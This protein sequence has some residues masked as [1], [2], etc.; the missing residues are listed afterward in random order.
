MSFAFMPFFTG[1]YLRDTRH[2]T[3]AKHGIFLLLL[4]HCWDQKGPVPIDEQEA[5]GIAN[6]RSADEIES[7]RYIL[8]KY[9]VRMDD[10]WYNRRMQAEVERSDALSGKRREAGKIGAAARVKQL[11][12]KGNLAIAGK[13]QAIAK[14]VPHTP[15]PTLTPINS[16][17]TPYVPSATETAPAEAGV[18]VLEAPGSQDPEP[19]QVA[20]PHDKVVRV[21]HEVLPELP[22]IRDWHER[23]QVKLRTLWRRMAAKKKWDSQA[24]GVDFFRRYFAYVRGCPLLMGAAPGRTWSADLEWLVNVS[25]FTKVIEGK[26]LP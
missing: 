25:N 23:R 16:K 9:F 3:P 21:Y 19:Q 24:Q 12:Q 17:A 26:Y 13:S 14:Q 6:C 5:A 20:C 18:L 10:G 22:A 11:P 2:L 7:L 4:M 1:D 8:L 15:T